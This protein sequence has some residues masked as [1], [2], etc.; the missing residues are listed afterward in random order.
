MRSEL[1]APP[2]RPRILGRSQPATRQPK[3]PLY[4]V[5]LIVAAIIACGISTTWHEAAKPGLRSPSE[6][7]SQPAPTP[8]PAPS[9]VAPAP[10][11][12][13]IKLP[14]PRAALVRLPEWQVGQ[15][16]QLLMPY[17]IQTLGTLKGRL[18]S[19]DLLP[20]TGNQLGDAWAV[21]ENIR[22][23]LAAPGA[24]TPTWIDP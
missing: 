8:Q 16:R 9:V 3:G 11:A 1:G 5:L 13:L 23:W 21:G 19:P 7:I 17:G 12:E 10:R 6:S 4:L 14:P 20:A 15:N 2:K 24:T 22:V 18:T